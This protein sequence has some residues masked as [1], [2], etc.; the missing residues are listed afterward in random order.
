MTTS[1]RVH[2]HRDN[3]WHGNRVGVLIL[4]LLTFVAAG[5]D[6]T[7]FLFIGGTFVSNQTGTVLLLAMD[8]GGA[9]V[10]NSVSAVASLVMFILGATV[11]A[12][13]LPQRGPGELL[14]RRTT[15]VLIGEVVLLAG[16]V[17]LSAAGDSSA[18]T[19]ALLGFCMGA[20][21]ALAAR[22]ALPYLTTGFITGSLTKSLLESPAGGPPRYGWWYI[23]APVGTIAFGAL[24]IGWIA[25]ESVTGAIALLGVLVIAAAILS[26]RSPGEVR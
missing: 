11:G 15:I 26:R 5:A 25:R 3:P 24:V 8:V 7:T 6:A 9:N 19:V 10:V 13:L 18:W 4:L 16:A 17:A 22:I 14:P 20:Q 23:A 2:V 1:G 12:R 21:A